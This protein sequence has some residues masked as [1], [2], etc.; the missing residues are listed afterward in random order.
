[1]PSSLEVSVGVEVS[2][3]GLTDGGEYL[4]VSLQTQVGK[5]WQKVHVL[6]CDKHADALVKTENLTN[7][8]DHYSQFHT[9]G[10]YEQQV[11]P[12]L[13]GN[14]GSGQYIFPRKGERQNFPYGVEL[15]TSV[16][17]VG[18]LMKRDLVQYAQK[19]YGADKITQQIRSDW[20]VQAQRREGCRAKTCR[21]HDRF[22]F[23][24]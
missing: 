24:A 1:M 10:V 13:D 14:A 5:G 12:P 11:T 18:N 4:E 3:K 19:V 15:S 23:T 7:F 21:V 20:L 16:F 22:D 2:V 9:V 6:P 17:H 8:D